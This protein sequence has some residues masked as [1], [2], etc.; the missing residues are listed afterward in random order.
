MPTLVSSDRVVGIGLALF[1]GVLCVVSAQA[2]ANTANITGL[3]ITLGLLVL[4]ICFIWPEVGIYILILS[5]LLGPEI[6]AGNLTGG[7]GTSERGVTLRVDDFLLLIIAFAW[8]ARG[9]VYQELGLFLS[10][11]LNKPIMAYLLI[12]LLS[13]VVGILFD[14]VDPVT[15]F[16]YVL[17]YVEYIFVYFAVVNF[18]H[19]KAQARRLIWVLFIT[20]ILVAIYAGIQIPLGVRVSAPF[21]GESGEPN[22]LGGY[23]ILLIALY[24]GLLVSSDSLRK[25]LRYAVGITILG[26]PLLFTLSRASYLGIFA[27]GVIIVMFSR[28]K[29]I[30]GFAAVTFIL[31]LVLFAPS[32]VTERIQYTFGGQRARADQIAVGNVRLDTSTSARLISYQTIISDFPK[33]PILGYGVTGYG[34]IDGQYPRVLI[35][36]G[37]LGLA[38]FFWLLYSLFRQGWAALRSAT[39]NWEQGVCIGFL[40]GLT[41]LVMHA[42]GSNTFMIVRI[43]EP[44]WL[45]AG[46]VTALNIFNSQEPETEEI[47][48]EPPVNKVSPTRGL[49]SPLSGGPR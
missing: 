4:L 49:I 22:T 27:A 29:I 34:F 35:E 40:A 20:G 13:T 44:F 24:A 15:G 42:L 28:Q 33:Q 17:K 19:D 11:P 48:A 23:L 45:L 3:A 14:R 32:S 30:A 9:A 26:I 21:E 38:A 43:M 25:G 1:V 36:M 2:I 16:F 18:I 41:G 31:A 39:D 37:L 8:L 10:T 46:I 5:M 6:I 12:A 47:P 7:G